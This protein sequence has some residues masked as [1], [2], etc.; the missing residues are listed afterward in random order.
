MTRAIETPHVS[1]PPKEEIEWTFRH[2]LERLI[3]PTPIALAGGTAILSGASYGRSVTVRARSWFAAR[4]L[5][6]MKLGISRDEVEL[7]R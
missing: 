3:R 7:A 5:A 1:P 6:A 4:D 2:V